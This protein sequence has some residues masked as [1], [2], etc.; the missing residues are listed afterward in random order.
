M[1]CVICN[2]EIAT[3][4]PTVQLSG[5]F[6]QQ[7]EPTGPPIFVPEDEVLSESFIHRT[8]LDTLVEANV[9]MNRTH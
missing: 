8:C 1:I 7:F 9:K 2:K 3:N 5:G 6:F 4:T